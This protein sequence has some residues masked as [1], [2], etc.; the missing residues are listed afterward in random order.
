M[1]GKIVIDVPVQG[2]TSDPS[3]KVGKVVGR[4]I[5]NLLTKVAVSPFALLGSFFGGGG[6]E[7]AYQE[8]EA[9]KAEIKPGEVKKLETM[10]KALTNRPG[11]SLDLQGSYEAAVDGPALKPVK[12][13]DSVK[14]AIWE[15][16]HSANPNTP[17]PSQLEITPEEEA[18]MIKKIYDDRFPPG[19]RFGAP[20][21]A[22]PE[23]LPAPPPP[24]GVFARFFG[25]LSNRAEREAKAVQEENARRLA[26]HARALQAA[27]STGL[28]LEDMRKRLIADTEVEEND[29][30]NLAQAR[31]QTVRDYFTKVGKVSADRLF[32][33]KDKV[34]PAQETKG[35]RVSLGLQ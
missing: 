12:F 9:G 13:A 3:F 21:P 2:S 33:A 10:V 18:A 6:D 22:P 32:L 14:R 27:I 4:V 8:F 24:A 29:L 7:L 20:I 34:D 23:M 16:K 17:P 25:A 26:E 11:L 30:R 28:P 19:T 1:D 35:A 31:A 5:V 15:Q